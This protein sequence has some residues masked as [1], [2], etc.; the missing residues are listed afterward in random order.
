MTPL[1]TAILDQHAATERLAREVAADIKGSGGSA[2]DVA[3][4]LELLRAQ[5]HR[6]ADA[7]VDAEG[8]RQPGKPRFQARRYHAA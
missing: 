5:L 7:L 1:E 3:D 6:D 2:R 8:Q 4:A